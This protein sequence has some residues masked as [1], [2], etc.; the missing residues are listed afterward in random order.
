MKL[1]D[2]CSWKKSYDRPRQSTEKQ[3]HYFADKV[4]IVKDMVFLVVMYGCESQTIKKAERQRTDGFELWCWIRLES[5]LDYRDCKPV[6]PKGNQAWMFVGI[7]AAEPETPIL[8]PP[9]AKN[10]L[11]GKDPNAVKDWR[12]EEKCE[13]EE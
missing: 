12:Q 3:S 13:T 11:I 10:W 9:D 4:H 7:T 1:R 2:T 8:W 5:P 6:N